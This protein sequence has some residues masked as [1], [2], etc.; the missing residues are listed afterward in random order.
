M[1]SS[2]RAPSKL[3]VD[4]G[5]GSSTSVPHPMNRP[6][7]PEKSAVRGLRH[8]PRP[9]GRNYFQKSGTPCDKGVNHEKPRQPTPEPYGFTT[10]ELHPDPLVK[11]RNRSRAFVSCRDIE[12]RSYE[13]PRISC[14]IL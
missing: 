6:E 4:Y 5:R 3:P 8:F 1:R 9:H 7:I 14:S 12:F 10:A 2:F 13:T 11:E